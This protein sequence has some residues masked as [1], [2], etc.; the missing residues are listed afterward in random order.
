MK[1]G[2]QQILDEIENIKVRGLRED[3][4]A[5]RLYSYIVSSSEELLRSERINICEFSKFPSSDISNENLF[6][7]YDKLFANQNRTEIHEVTQSVAK[8]IHT[9]IYATG[10]VDADGIMLILLHR[11]IDE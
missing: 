9:S 1:T 3:E 7:L 5:S 2:L 4:V 8:Y 10:K 11:L 6:K